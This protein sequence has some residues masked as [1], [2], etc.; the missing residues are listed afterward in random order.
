MFGE[1]LFFSGGCQDEDVLNF[2]VAA[3]IK[4]Y[5]IFHASTPYEI[6]G[7]EIR[8]ALCKFVTS[9]KTEGLWTAFRAIYPIVGDTLDKRKF[10]LRNPADTDAAF[11]LSGT[12]TN[13][14]NG[15][16]SVGSQQLSTFCTTTSG[17]TTSSFFPCFVYCQSNIA[18]TTAGVILGGGTNLVLRH[19]NNTLYFRHNNSANPPPGLIQSFTDSRGVF[20]FGRRFSPTN[21]AWSLINTGAIV[22]GIY[23]RGLVATTVVLFGTVPG[24]TWT[25]SQN[26]ISFLAV[27]NISSILSDSAI[28][29]V[30]TCIEILQED[31]KRKV[32]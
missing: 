3:D 13:E 21:T 12:I 25:R 19:T 14:P 5:D 28:L 26:I 30:K 16:R 29:K 6:S 24:Q 7:L 22:T 11:R 27:G 10:N 17:D 4:D 1:E 9:M 31:L 2:L 23:P 8:S 18:E 15:F 32:I 20:G